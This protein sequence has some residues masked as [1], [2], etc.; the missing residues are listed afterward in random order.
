MNEKL[1]SSPLILVVEPDDETRPLL[2]HNLKSQGYGVIAALDEEDAIEWLKGGFHHPALILLNQFKQSI[3]EA[4]EI[5]RRICTTSE[6]PKDTP[7]VVLA[8]QYGED[9]E[10]QDVQVSDREYV[11]YL[12]DGQQ[13]MNLLQKL[14]PV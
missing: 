9:L 13:L 1:N 11:T 2:K 3:E 6:L 4:L 12:E 5:G 10:G 8:E 14:C 7:I